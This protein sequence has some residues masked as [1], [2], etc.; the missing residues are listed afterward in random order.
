MANSALDLGL[1][2][3]AAS[4]WA[5]LFGVLDRATPWINSFV[6]L[7]LPALGAAIAAL[8]LERVGSAGCDPAS[9]AATSFSCLIH[10]HQMEA[11]HGGVGLRIAGV[12]PKR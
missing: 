6:G 9:A 3:G 1:V 4:T 12:L 5:M 7:G 2:N 10:P 11:G 8:A